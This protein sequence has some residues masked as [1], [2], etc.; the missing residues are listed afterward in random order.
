[1][2]LTQIRNSN[3]DSSAQYVGFKNRIINGDMRIDQRNAGAS[4]TLTDA[5]NNFIVD[6]FVTYKLN[7]SVTITGQQSSVSP[8]GFS[9]S[10]LFTTTTGAAIGAANEGQ[11]RQTFEGYNIADL[12]WGTASASSVTLSFWVRSSLTGSFAVAIQTNFVDAT[13]VATYNVVSANTWEYKTIVIPGSTSGTF[14]S[15]NGVGFSIIWDL[16]AGSNFNTTAGAWTSGNKYSVAGTQK[17]MGTSGATFYIT[18]VQ[19]EKGSV[20]TSFDYRDY[21]RELAMCQRYYEVGGQQ[22]LMLFASD[23]SYR[24]TSG[25]FIVTKRASPTFSIISG[26]NAS[27]TPTLSTTG[28]YYSGNGWTAGSGYNFAG[29]TASAEL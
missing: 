24:A 20:A 2:P 14:S 15:T 10:L 26:G 25:S 17:V 22:F 4:V 19:L 8:V 18:G 23:A 1:M 6:R 9:K 28:W 16:G 21:G 27:F 29:Y 7:S 5:G 13:Y 3:I 12:G 11:F